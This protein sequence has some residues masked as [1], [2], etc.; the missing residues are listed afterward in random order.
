MKTKNINNAEFLKKF[1]QEYN[2]LYSAPGYVAGYD[3]A[4]QAFDDFLG[5]SESNKK[6]VADFARFRK[7]FISSDR[8]AAAFMFT[9]DYF[10]KN[11]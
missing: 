3:E 5:S 9:L 4:V 8:E 7:D 1:N 10:E 2:F 11:Y 6:L